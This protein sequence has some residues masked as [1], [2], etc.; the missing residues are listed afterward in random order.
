VVRL[1]VSRNSTVSIREQLSAQ[2]V[3]GIVSGRLAP[4]ERLPSVRALARRLRIHPNTVSAAYSDLAARGWVGRRRGS[5]VFVGLRRLAPKLETEPPDLTGFVRQFVEQ[6]LRYG[7]SIE[8]MRLALGAMTRPSIA[9]LA[10][11]D[12]DLELARVLATEVGDALGLQVTACEFGK[13]IFK[14]GDCLLGLAANEAILR[15]AAGAEGYRMLK[16]KS[17]ED[18]VGGYTRPATPILIGMVSRSE[19]IRRWAEPLLSS[20]GFGAPAVLWRTPDDAD[21][22]DGLERCGIVAADALSARDCPGALNALV[23]RIVAE[24][25]IEEL[26]GIMKGGV[27]PR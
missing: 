10:V 26:R 6:G 18:L 27:E 9:A 1:W 16:L 17:M 8:S 20:L 3:L 19:S 25:S 21:W 5:G 22:T 11:A 15:S 4:G 12:T 14:P 13:F 7:Y 2:L 23:F 24:E